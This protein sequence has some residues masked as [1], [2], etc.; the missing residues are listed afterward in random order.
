MSQIVIGRGPVWSLIWDLIDD[1]KEQ[2]ISDGRRNRLVCTKDPNGLSICIEKERQLGT[3]NWMLFNSIICTNKGKWIQQWLRLQ[4][5]WIYEK[6][7]SQWN[8]RQSWGIK[9][10]TDALSSSTRILL[11]Q[12]FPSLREAVPATR[13]RNNK[14]DDG[15]KQMRANS[16]LGRWN[17]FKW[18]RSRSE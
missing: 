7:V 17:C 3:N 15:R 4:R 2:M 9:F 5:S 14:D 10:V 8:C 12:Y 11:L 18:A 16:S 1:D 6:A 13:K